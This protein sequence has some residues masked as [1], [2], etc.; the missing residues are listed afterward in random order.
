M[1]EFVIHLHFIAAVSSRLLASLPN[2]YSV[3]GDM[4]V[5]ENL[6]LICTEVRHKNKKNILQTLPKPAPF[7]AV[8]CV[9]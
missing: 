5:K 4:L 6:D 7:G 2:I 9:E 3:L 8:P 1:N